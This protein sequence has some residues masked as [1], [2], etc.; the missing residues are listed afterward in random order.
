MS[1]DNRVENAKVKFDSNK[2]MLVISVPVDEI[3]SAG[4]AEKTSK[5]NYNLA[6]SH[7]WCKV[8]AREGVSFSF[9][10][11]MKKAVYEAMQAEKVAKVQEEQDARTKEQL[12]KQAQRAGEQAQKALEKHAD[13]FGVSD[14]R[15]RQDMLEEKID[16]LLE[17]LTAPK[18]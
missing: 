13:S 4:K 16:M 11:T 1:K 8:E 5:G 7:G 14:L 18:K 17:V 6:S 9:N 15:K 3:L 12:N 10:C 2:G